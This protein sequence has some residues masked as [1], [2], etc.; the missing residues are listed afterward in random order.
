MRPGA[1]KVSLH[2]RE[3][4]WEEEG[5]GGMVEGADPSNFPL[6][7]KVSAEMA[8][9]LVFFFSWFVPSRPKLLSE[10][11]CTSVHYLG[12]F[13]NP[14]LDKPACRWIGTKCLCTRYIW[15]LLIWITQPLKEWIL[16]ICVWY[17]QDGFSILLPMKSLLGW[18]LLLWT[19]GPNHRMK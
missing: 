2:F 3:K 13:L 6:F 7:S 10:T 4:S 9:C 1:R 5:D 19:T 15:K 16:D 14:S 12:I 11:K 17:S 8:Q 18:L